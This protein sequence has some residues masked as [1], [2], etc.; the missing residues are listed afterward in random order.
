MASHAFP[1]A[2]RGLAL[3]AVLQPVM[4]DHGRAMAAGGAAP[5]GADCTRLAKEAQLGVWAGQ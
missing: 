3:R 4:R 1:P 2:P 5:P